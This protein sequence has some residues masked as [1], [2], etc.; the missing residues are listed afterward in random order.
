LADIE[1][2]SKIMKGLNITLTLLLK[3]AEQQIQAV[4][5]AIIAA[6]SKP[7]SH[8]IGYERD[9][10]YEVNLAAFQKFGFFDN[11]KRTYPSSDSRRINIIQ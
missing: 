4:Q 10:Q 11:D 7:V 6:P 3:K 1:N 5:K 2:N 9:K 8:K